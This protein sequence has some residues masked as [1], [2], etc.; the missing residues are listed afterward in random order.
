MAMKELRTITLVVL[1]FLIAACTGKGKREDM[2]SINL[3]PLLNKDIRVNLSDCTDSIFYI[4]P[5]FT[6]EAI[7][8]S[9]KKVKLFEDKVII[10]DEFNRLFIYLTNGQYLFSI[11]NTGRGPGEHLNIWDFTI[12]N[13]I[14]FI[15][16]NGMKILKYNLQGEFLDELSLSTGFLAM[17]SFN[18]EL[19][20]YT[21]LPWSLDN[22]M[23]K[24]SAY[25]EDLL[26]KGRYYPDH[27]GETKL[28][29]GLN[30]FFNFYILRD[31]LSVWETDTDTVYRFSDKMELIPAYRF[32][33]GHLSKAIAPGD[34]KSPFPYF[35]FETNSYFLIDCGFNNTIK[36]VFLN[37][38]DLKGGNVIFDYEILDHGFVNDI[39]GGYPFWPKGIS[40]QGDL[41]TWFEP[42]TLKRY[43]GYE[44]FTGIEIK[45]QQTAKRLRDLINSTNDKSNPIIMVCRFK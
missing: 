31:T 20:L 5:E 44:E 26:L 41:L 21:Q 16:D 45:D 19:L 36:A 17:F 15:L 3:I 38:K 1:S 7:P 2:V 12:Q 33:Y 32:Y 25:S 43:L 10:L 13:G 9:F 8:G 37:K 11:T 24:I 4:Q 27:S 42:L 22:D 14:L 6:I 28:E 39:D 35:L 29:A 18:D 40:D 34:S 30:T 23:Y